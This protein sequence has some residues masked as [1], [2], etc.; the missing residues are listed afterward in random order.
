MNLVLFRNLLAKFH[1]LLGG[2]KEEAL[3]KHNR[4]YTAVGRQGGHGELDT[5][6]D[7]VVILNANALNLLI[8]KEALRFGPCIV[9]DGLAIGEL[10]LLPLG[11]VAAIGRVH[12]AIVDRKPR[13]GCARPCRDGVRE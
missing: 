13:K 7:L 2:T 3:R 8:H 1:A 4:T 5:C 9:L 6:R 12:E 11:L 10:V